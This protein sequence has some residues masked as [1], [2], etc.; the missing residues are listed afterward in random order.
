MP[1][2]ARS[3]RR[4]GSFPARRRADSTA[5]AAELREALVPWLPPLLAGAALLTLYFLGHLHVVD[6]TPALA[7][8]AF[9]LVASVLYFPMRYARRLEGWSRAGAALYA[10]AWLTVVYYPIYWRIYPGT[11][12]ASVDATPDSVPL[13]LQTAGQ[14]TLLDLM[15]DGDLERPSPGTTRAARYS[16][17]VAADGTEPQTIAGEFK[18]S[19][20]RQ[21]QGRRDAV[22]VLTER[23]SRLVAIR[24]PGNGDLEIQALS[25]SGDAAPGLTISVY[26][27][28]LPPWWVGVAAAALLLAGAVAF[29]HA[30]GAGD[31]AAS[32]VVATGTAV[33]GAFVFPSLGSPHPSFR[34]LAGAAIIGGLVG[35][36]IGGLVGWVFRQP[37]KTARR[38]SRTGGR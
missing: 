2:A 7:I 23:R 28:A 1:E 18:E 3:S 13:R 36:P 6:T 21:R 30:T 9:L 22:E 8:D 4:R 16:I 37:A 12:L 17:T 10:V 35:G 19:W 38:R 25:V 33:T 29:D 34:E 20:F 27:H 11:R 14:G 32:M 24:N 5:S 31:T 15:I 26:P